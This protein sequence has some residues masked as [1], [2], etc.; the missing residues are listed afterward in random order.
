M[1]DP[2]YRRD[3][4]RIE[5][6]LDRV[7]TAIISLA[8][9]EERLVTLFNR[10]DRHDGDYRDL[11]KRVADIERVTF[12]RRSSIVWADSRRSAAFRRSSA[13]CESEISADFRCWF[14]AAF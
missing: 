14:V 13:T 2:D 5:T 7:E 6:K 4:A 12:G 11:S 8:R 3:L 10:M 9:M 1:T